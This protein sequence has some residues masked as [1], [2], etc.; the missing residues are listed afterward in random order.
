MDVYSIEKRKWPYIVNP[1]KTIQKI[2]GMEIN[3]DEKKRTRF[4]RIESSR[5]LKDIIKM[6][7]RKSKYKP[8]YA[9]GFWKSRLTTSKH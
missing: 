3:E 2:L 8:V 5:K 1:S 4:L 7:T 9:F 6:V